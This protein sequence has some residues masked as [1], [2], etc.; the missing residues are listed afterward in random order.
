MQKGIEAIIKTKVYRAQ[1][2]AFFNKN[3]YYVFVKNIK[4]LHFFGNKDHCLC[5]QGLEYQDKLNK[6]SKKTEHCPIVSDVVTTHSS[7]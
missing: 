2:N 1:Q 4:T 6:I 7:V 3:T 5:R